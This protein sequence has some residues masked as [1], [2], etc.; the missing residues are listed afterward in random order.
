MITMSAR[1]FQRASKDE[2]SC[3]LANTVYG[4]G[5]SFMEQG[6]QWPLGFLGPKDL[7]EACAAAL[8]GSIG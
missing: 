1:P 7:Q 6:W 2:A 8:T 4:K 5:L 3:I